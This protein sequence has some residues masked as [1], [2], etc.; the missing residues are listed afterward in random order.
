M[1][2]GRSNS[3]VGRSTWRNF[4]WTCKSPF[5]WIAKVGIV[6]ARVIAWIVSVPLWIV[7]NSIRLIGTTLVACVA[8]LTPAA[9][10]WIASLAAVLIGRRGLSRLIGLLPTSATLLTTTLLTT[11][12]LSTALR[13]TTSALAWLTAGRFFCDRGVYIAATC[14]A[15]KSKFCKAPFCMVSNIRDSHLI[16]SKSH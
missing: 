16:H 7:G 15:E 12:T 11:S 9:L 10:A 13:L 4:V 14:K 3:I 8:I 2:D 1:I 5:V 6:R